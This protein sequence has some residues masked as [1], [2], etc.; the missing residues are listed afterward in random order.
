MSN[1]SL[2]FSLAPAI[3]FAPV[4]HFISLTRNLTLSL[5]TPSPHYHCLPPASSTYQSYRF[6]LLLILPHLRPLTSHLDYYNCIQLPLPSSPISLWLSIWQPVWSFKSAN[7]KTSLVAQWLRLQTPKAR[8]KCS[9][10]DQGTKIP[11]AAQ[12]G[13]TKQKQQ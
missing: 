10:P 11:Y 8:G 4:S 7:T 5:Q 12:Y 1:R 6:Y 2:N 9:I 3:H 13:R